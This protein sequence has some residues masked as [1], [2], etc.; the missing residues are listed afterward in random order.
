M[1]RGEVF[2]I[3]DCLVVIVG[4]LKYMIQNKRMTFPWKFGSI[5]VI[6][7]NI[8]CNI[9]TVGKIPVQNKYQNAQ[10]KVF[11]RSNKIHQHTGMNI[12]GISI[13]NQ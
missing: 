9:V 6:R 4:I 3:T 10:Y 1:W 13:N 2:A 7:L 11:D 5:H 8:N 12:N